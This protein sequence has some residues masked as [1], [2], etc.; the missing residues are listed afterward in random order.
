M[1]ARWVLAGV[2]LLCAGCQLQM[3]LALTFDR[4]GAGDLAVAV[5]ADPALQAMARSAGADPL[6]ELAAAGEELADRGWQ[7]SDT[8]DD[9]GMRTVTLSADFT[10]PR[11]FEQL[12]EQLAMALSSPEVDLLT[13]LTLTVDDEQLL[14]A[15]AASLRPTEVVAEL[16]LTPE[17]AVALLRDEDGFAYTVAVDMPGEVLDTTADR[18]EDGTLRWTV[19]P[20]E[21]V[22]IHAVGRRPGPPMWPLVVGALAGLVVAAVVLRRLAV[23]RRRSG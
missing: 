9:Q 17:Q 21:Q 23:V 7:T 19:E 6:R 14:L 13:P 22:R 2:T 12:A 8:V 3:D 10:G 1:W 16:G 4:D 15:G 20:G 11:V 18:Q 5:T